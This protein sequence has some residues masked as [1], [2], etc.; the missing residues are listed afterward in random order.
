MAAGGGTKSVDD[1]DDS[2][3][4]VVQC[5]TSTPRAPFGSAT[6]AGMRWS[7]IRTAATRTWVSRREIHRSVPLQESTRARVS[8]G[9]VV[10]DSALRGAQITTCKRE[11]ARKIRP[12]LNLAAQPAPQN[13]IWLNWLLH[14]LTLHQFVPD[15]AFGHAAR[16]SALHVLG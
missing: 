6:R 13:P 3:G 1:D 16:M 5:S 14:S 9:V 15:I 12:I 8:A 2:G 4:G 10:M 11:L 7:S